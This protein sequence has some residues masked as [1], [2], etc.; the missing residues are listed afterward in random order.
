MKPPQTRQRGI[1]L[2]I[3][4]WMIT[5]LTI[6]A[7]SFV[8]S[9]R[10]DTVLM[11]NLVA[12][13]KAQA[14][15]DAGIHRAIYELAQPAVTLESWRA[16][17]QS[18]ELATDQG[19]ILVTITSE[20]GKI[21]INSA[22]D[23]L[24]LVLLQSAGLEGEAA[25]SVRDAI[26]DWRD[27]DN[28]RRPLGAEAPEYEAAGLQYVPANNRFSSIE[29]LRQV[30]GVSPALYDRLAGLI[31]VYSQAAGV[32]TGMA[33][34]E[35]LAIF[36][37]ADPATVDA[38]IQERQALRAPGVQAPAFAPAAAYQAGGGDDAAAYAIVADAQ[39]ADGSRFI[40]AAVA[41]IVPGAANSVNFMA[42]R[43]LA[44]PNMTGK[45]DEN[46]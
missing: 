1:A 30:M 43:S 2:V 16:D 11:T 22:Q 31:T 24:L 20:T 38:Y 18:H 41:R 27:A 34:R 45:V 8:Y 40:R 46:R 29:E 13:A 6:I 19:R 12:S 44:L 25:E 33:P 26:L 5:L 32:N 4:L 23:G 10:T 15:A 28:L 14:L 9:T 42:W 3:V 21:D 7:G 17:G 37:G 39:L 36:P 35:V